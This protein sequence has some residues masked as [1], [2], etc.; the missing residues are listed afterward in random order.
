MGALTRQ[1]EAG[2]GTILSVQHGDHFEDKLKLV[3]HAGIVEL[4][5]SYPIER[6]C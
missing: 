2:D 1:I 5:G 6:N 4:L 3:I